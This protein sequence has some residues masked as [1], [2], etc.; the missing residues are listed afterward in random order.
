MHAEAPLFSKETGFC[1]SEVIKVPLVVQ[2]WDAG[3]CVGFQE[4]GCSW[5]YCVVT[6]GTL[7]PPVLS[8]GPKS[9]TRNETGR[10]FKRDCP[11]VPMVR[12]GRGKTLCPSGLS[13]VIGLPPPAECSCLVPSPPPAPAFC[14]QWPCW[15][16]RGLPEPCWRWEAPSISTQMGR[17][18]PELSAGPS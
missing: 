16:Q 7:N 8:L 12:A 18:T 2:E 13:R 9:K 17:W 6:A 15:S 3:F 4:K 5:I 10:R 11:T 1:L 14:T